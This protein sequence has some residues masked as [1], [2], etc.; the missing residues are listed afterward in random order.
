MDYGFGGPT[1][2]PGS[3]GRSSSIIA[4][5]TEHGFLC[6][7]LDGE[8]YGVDLNM[9]VQIVKPPPLTRVPR[10]RSH[11]LGVI[12]I[13]GAVVTLIDLRLLM[14]LAASEW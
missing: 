6:F 5:D 8:E 7:T 1:L 9:I 13:R 4:A 3:S 2:P 11:V 10:V 14:D 12:S